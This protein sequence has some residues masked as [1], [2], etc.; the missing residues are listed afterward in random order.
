MD[1]AA[2]YEVLSVVEEIPPGRVATYGQ[3]AELAGRAGQARLIG[4]ILSRAQCYGYY[5]CH[6]VVDHTG[7]LAPGWLEQ[8]SL[9][10]AEGVAFKNAAHVDLK[11][12]RW[13]Y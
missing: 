9:L 1:E 8:R 13:E 12:C 10:E 5:P 3:I 6:R 2:V 4:K 11:K 7:R